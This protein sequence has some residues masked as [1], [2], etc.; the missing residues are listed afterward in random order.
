MAKETS[1]TR[2]QQWKAMHPD[3]AKRA[4]A[5]IARHQKRPFMPPMRADKEFAFES[6]YRTAKDQER[7]WALFF[8]ALGTRQCAVV[9]MFFRQLESLVDRQWRA[10]WEQW[11]AD[12]EQMIAAFALIESLKPRNVAQAA[13]AAQLFALHIC[14][15]KLARSATCYQHGDAR[16]TATLARSIRAYGDGLMTM[17][18]LQ[19]K[20]GQRSSQTIKVEKHSHN[21]Q[22]IHIEGGSENGGQPYGRASRA[23]AE[24]RSLPSPEPIGFGVPRSG[25]EGKAGLPKPRGRKSRRSEG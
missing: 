24:L 2:K 16:T 4:D 10:D 5:A 9:T 3:L 22:H 8:E 17:R 13:L 14:T 19:G 25:N 12:E 21:H 7:W 23:I 1:P 11:V 15:M 6:P 18:K 20:G